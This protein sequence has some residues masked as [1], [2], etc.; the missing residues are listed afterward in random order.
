MANDCVQEG[1][2]HA[3]P[4]HRDNSRFK[5]F[6]DNGKP[7]LPVALEGTLSTKPIF[8]IIK[9]RTVAQ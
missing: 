5:F 9:E 8:Q 7:E 1:G 6:H 3:A 2:R 4:L